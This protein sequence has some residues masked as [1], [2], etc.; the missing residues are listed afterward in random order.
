MIVEDTEIEVIET[1]NSRLSQVDFDSIPF[2]RVFSDHMFQMDYENGEWTNISI[3]PYGPIPMAPSA[4]VLHYG[5]AIF[6]G[7]KAYKT[8]DGKVGLFR[9]RENAKRLNE[10]AVRMCMPEIPV[11]LFIEGLSKLIQM[12]HN[13]IPQKRGSS[14]YIRPFMFATD[15]YIGVKASQTYKFLIFTGPVG[16]YYNNPLKLKVERK[17][18]RAAKGGF[19][20]AKAAGNYAG[21]LYPAKLAKE[22]GFDQL[23]WTDSVE[24]EYVEESG[25]M[26][27]GFFIDD[28]FY[29]P[30][31]E[32]SILKGITRNSVIQ[33]LKE[34]GVK[35]NEAPISIRF[36]RE[37]FENLRVKE[38]FGIG[39]A[40]TIAPVE[41]IS[42]D[43][44]NFNIPMRENPY[45]LKLKNALE[46]IRT[47]RQEDVFN[48]MT[49]IQ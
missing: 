6:E 19:G 15:T 8:E 38:A 25:T 30:P 23:L 49:W 31:T 35:V 42:I 36:L 7:M 33:L 20:Q 21:S 28:E 43:G 5:Q 44:T 18:S 11:D 37:C 14:L 45:S 10:S 34:W 12:D 32:G 41:S 27:I 17:Y 9:P 29:T 26:N 46:D 40:A 2:G 39:T 24:H 13:W 47:G 16:S 3:C 48:W 4:S 22:E 1:S